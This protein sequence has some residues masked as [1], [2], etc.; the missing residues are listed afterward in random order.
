MHQAAWEL[1]FEVVWSGLHSRDTWCR[2]SH[3]YHDHERALSLCIRPDATP[4][5]ALRHS[6]W[7]YLDGYASPSCQEIRIGIIWIVHTR[8]QRP[9]AAV[10]WTAWPPLVVLAHL[11]N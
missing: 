6:G 8:P 11:R 3:T 10:T 2:Y 4:V 7:L 1:L 5:R 9:V